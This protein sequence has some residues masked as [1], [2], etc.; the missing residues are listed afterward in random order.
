MNHQLKLGIL[1]GGQ[2][3]KMLL[4]VAANYPVVT[5]V[6]ENDP[7][8]PSA[9]L[10]TEFQQ[11]NINDFDTVYA[12]GKKVDVLT[13]EIEHVNVAALHQLK[14]EGL[15]I[16]PSPECLEIIKDKGIQKDF[17]TKNNIPTSAYFHVENKAA[18]LAKEISFPFVQK[19][20]TGGYDGK[21][22]NVIKSAEDFDKLFDA[23]SIIEEAIAIKKEIAVIV[24]VGQDFSMKAYPPTEMVFD[25][26]LNL[27]D[28]L[29]SPANITESLANKA[30]AIAENV[31]KALASPGIFAV[32]LFLT[33]ADEILVNEIAP[34]AHNSG[35]HTI[36]GN[37]T[38]QYD[39]QMRIFQR[40]PLGN[41][42]IILP[43][44]M[45][46]I[47]GEDNYE[48]AAKNDYLQN[49]LSIANTYIHLYG[50]TISKPGR[51][52]G[53]ITT[54][55]ANFDELQNKVSTLKI[56]LKS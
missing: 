4:Q 10:C 47:I 15:T 2:L 37:F 9:K 45:L 16:I 20:N 44:A 46:N 12:F 38:S 29:L 7:N 49:C 39:M 24:A 36:E 25:E 11:G 6:L 56:A 13:I 8:C 33:D 3:G 41:T 22:V 28:Y 5:C 31:V 52:M 51:K 43:A 55:A 1:G 26:K 14:K 42:A 53:H 48:G 50:K 21:G 35:H 17:Y 54:L 40:L 19:I 30:I 18:I 27:V 32:E 34:R 23:P